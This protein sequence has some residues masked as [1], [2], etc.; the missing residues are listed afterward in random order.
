MIPNTP[1]AALPPAEFSP[2]VA[3]TPAVG[4][5]SISLEAALYGTLS[6]NPDLAALRQGGPNLPSPEAVEVARNFPTTL[7]PTLWF[8]LRPIT[9]IPNNTFGTT[10][11]NSTGGAAP[12]PH[13]RGPYTNGNVFLYMS[14]R[15][16]VE[17][18]HQTTQR[19]NIAKAALN[20]Q[21]WTVVQA[22]LLALVQ[23]YRFFQTAAYRRERF[24][25]ARQLADFND[26]LVT[27]LRG[28]LEASQVQAADV[29][30]AVVES[31]AARQQVKAAQQDYVTALTDLRNQMG[32]PET[33][34]AAEPL[35]AFTLPP[36][37][38][39]VD[40]QTMVQQAL[41]ERPE[42]QAARA[43]CQG[44]LAAVNLARG[45]RLPSPIIGPEYQID[46]VGV[47]YVGFVLITPFPI[48]NN[49]KPL[50]RQREADYRRACYALRQ[51]EQRTVSQVRAA[52]AKWNGATELVNESSGL[53]E[54]LSKEVANLERLFDAGQADITRL[55]QARQRLIQLENAQLDALW[56]A[57]QAQADLLTALGSSSLIGS[58]L[59]TAKTGAIAPASSATPPSAAAPPPPNMPQ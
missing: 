35:G 49:G 34:G 48:L 25:V 18:G 10:S 40:E 19:Y 13:H 37:I 52:V 36:Y 12:A 50:L 47:Q 5:Q 2:V 1:A 51:I 46:E 16:P 39:P 32:I 26:R 41:R 11:N 23:T 22:E 6:G 53:T 30:L 14:Y 8:D 27:T 59:N 15:Q 7:N 3:P 20:Q 17:L 38:P 56:A 31:R 33:A 55:M 44:A 45:D 28:R 29:S 4:A 21:R 58:M 43:V 57:T 42:I 24:R 9:L 54:A